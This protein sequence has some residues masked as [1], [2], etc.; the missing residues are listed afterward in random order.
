MR[1]ILTLG[2][3]WAVAAVVAAVVAW[4]G[5]GLVGDQVTDQRPATLSAADVEA[6]LAGTATPTGARGTATTTSGPT[7]TSPAP[8]PTTAPAAPVVTTVLR[9]YPVTGGT[10]VL[11]FGPDGVVGLTATPW[12]GYTVRSNPHD[13]GG[14]RVEFE[15]P[16][17]RSR[18]DGWWDG[19]PQERVEDATGTRSG[20]DD[21][22][23]HG[24]GDD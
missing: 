8:P 13:G 22:D 23:D 6:E 11:S 21:A 14:W 19:G 4:Q 10:A 1:R 7:T 9:S 16:A 5:V 20:D 2:V 17:G 15:G 3:A 24:G 12:T 18:I